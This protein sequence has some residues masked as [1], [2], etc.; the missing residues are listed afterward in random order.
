MHSLFSRSESIHSQIFNNQF[1]AM[2]LVNYLNFPP[3]DMYFT[4]KQNSLV[5]K[6]KE[7]GIFIAQII[8]RSWIDIEILIF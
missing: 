6:K 3:R 5:I 4:F 7:I 2:N 8:I 1:E